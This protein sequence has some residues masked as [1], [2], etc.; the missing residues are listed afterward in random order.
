MEIAWADLERIPII[1]VRE[2]EGSLHDHCMVN[3]AAGFIVNTLDE[4]IEIVKA[5]LTP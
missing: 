3:E 2:A 5:I 1:I 4:G